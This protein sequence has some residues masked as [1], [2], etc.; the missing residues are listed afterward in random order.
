MD[1]SKCGSNS[2][3]TSDGGLNIG[4]YHVRQML[5]LR[6]YKMPELL[7]MKALSE[8]GNRNEQFE[9]IT[10]YRQY[11]TDMNFPI[12]SIDTKKREMIG[13]L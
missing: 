6:G 7:N 5:K 8:N 2:K 3:T 12:I 10:V 4:S 9:K 11:F 1:L 13:N